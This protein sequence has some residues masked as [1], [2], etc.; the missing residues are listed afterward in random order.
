LINSSKRD[1]YVVRIGAGGGRT[2]I[3]TTGTIQAGAGIIRG[4][5]G[6]GV[7]DKPLLRALA[8]SGGPIRPSQN[9]DRQGE[10]LRINADVLNDH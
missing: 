5:G 2:T 1:G 3:G 7:G 9:D 10:H 4:V 6:I 8:R